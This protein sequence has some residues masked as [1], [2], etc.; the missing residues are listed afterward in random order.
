MRI[1]EKGLEVRIVGEPKI[2][3]SKDGT[4][5]W[6][7]LAIISKR[8]QVGKRWKDDPEY[9]KTYVSLVAFDE[10]AEEL[11]DRNIQPGSIIVV[12]KGYIAPERGA[13]GISILMD[14]VSVP[15][16]KPTRGPKKGGRSE[17]EEPKSKGR[18][19][20]RVEEEEKEEDEDERPVR[21]RRSYRREE[22]EEFP[23]ESELPF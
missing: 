3:Y 16:E 11:A 6:R 18:M 4:P 9:S 7:G 10:L 20:A 22:D 15:S 8:M 12:Q 5:I 1:T 23:D 2:R 19:R 13:E 14:A 17:G 21:R